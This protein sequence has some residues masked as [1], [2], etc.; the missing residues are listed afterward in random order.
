MKNK[1]IVR[2]EPGMGQ[3]QVLFYKDEQLQTQESI[4]L[5]ELVSYLINTCYNENYDTVHFMG[6]WKFLEGIIEEFSRE[7]AT[8]YKTNK[9]YI[10][11][12]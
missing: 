3:Q 7:E 11:V 2:I 12:N 8:Q 10:E 1:I 4:P 6:N 5:D 9:I